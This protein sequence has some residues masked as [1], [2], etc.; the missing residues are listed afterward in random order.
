MKIYKRNATAI[1]LDGVVYGADEYGI[2]E[3]PDHKMNSGVWSQGFVSA[4]GRLEQIAK[5]QT[6]AQAQAAPEP[7]PNPQPEPAV[8]QASAKPKTSKA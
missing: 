6:N 5:A 7:G 8:S 1:T 2:I 3:I 4:Q